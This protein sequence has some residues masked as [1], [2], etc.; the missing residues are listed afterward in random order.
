MDDSGANVSVMPACMSTYTW[1]NRYKYINL[2]CYLR[3]LSCSPSFRHMHRTQF[4]I[5]QHIH[6]PHAR[7]FKLHYV[8]PHT[9]AVNNQIHTGK[10]TYL[11]I[12]TA[13]SDRQ[14]NGAD[15]LNIPVC[16]ECVPCVAPHPSS[17]LA[18]SNSFPPP[19]ITSPQATPSQ[20]IANKH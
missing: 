6:K 17:P 18:R 14:F 20:M 3:S 7:I 5:N 2:G 15:I 8:T 12:V 1:I 9:R 19:Y 11:T 13:Y 16:V 10:H 4:Q